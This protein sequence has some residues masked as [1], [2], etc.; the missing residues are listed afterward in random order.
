LY[1]F[2]SRQSASTATLETTKRGIGIPPDWEKMVQSEPFKRVPLSP[3][4]GGMMQKEYEMVAEKFQKTLAQAEILQIER[5]QN[6]YHWECY[7]L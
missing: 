3:R 7:Q 6:G 5:I 1:Y 4:A 2:P